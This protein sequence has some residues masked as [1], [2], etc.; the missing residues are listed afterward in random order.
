MTPESEEKKKNSSP[1]RKF[2]LRGLVICVFLLLLPFAGIQ[3]WK[4]SLYLSYKSL[5]EQNYQGDYVIFYS[6]DL[7]TMV[8][9]DDELWRMAQE[10]LRNFGCEIT[11]SEE[12][13]LP[14]SIHFNDAS[15]YWFITHDFHDCNEI[16]AQGELPR[17]LEEIEFGCISIGFEPITNNQSRITKD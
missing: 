11:Y 13:Y 2:L 9:S 6:N 10:C 17:T 7:D 1:R 8:M 5:W 15:K 14:K 12:S 4:Q 16:S 3:A